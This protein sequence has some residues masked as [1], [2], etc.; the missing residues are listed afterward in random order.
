[1][2]RPTVLL[3]LALTVLIGGAV[4][5]YGYSLTRWACPSYAEA[6]RPLR[7]AQVTQAFANGGLVLR[8]VPP[9]TAP[10]GG[11]LYRHAGRNA[12][13]VVY[14]CSK[15]CVP[16]LRAFPLRFGSESVGLEIVFRHVR[17]WATGERQARAL[18]LNKITPIV[19][20]LTPSTHEGRCF[21]GLLYPT[22][23]CSRR[24]TSAVVAA[25]VAAPALSAFSDRDG[26]DDERCQWVGPPPA[27]ESV[28][29]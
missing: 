19:S 15:Q 4:A 29:T 12:T 5:A 9:S 18:L 2:S 10:P 6:N 13:I 28:G 23:L 17:I 24:R 22:P 16:A 8:P 21:P 1:V 27:G 7:P 26:G 11:R 14:V 20:R 25:A 3:P